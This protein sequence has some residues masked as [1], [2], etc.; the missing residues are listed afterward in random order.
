M[1]SLR[2]LAAGFLWLGLLAGAAPA[3]PAALSDLQVFP[4][5]IS[6]FTSRGRQTFVVQAVHADG[7][8]RDVTAQAKVN[9]ANP[10]LVKLDRNVVLPV[11]A[12]TTELVVEFGGRTVKVPAEA[13]AA[14]V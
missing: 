10:S 8:T 1:G 5:D 2:T 11:A 9:P 4:P 13:K 6:L 14:K 7:I 12:G 3:G